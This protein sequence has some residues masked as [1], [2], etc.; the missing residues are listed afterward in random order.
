MKTNTW[1][2][3]A[4]DAL[5][6]I[7]RAAGATRM[8]GYNVAAEH[9]RLDIIGVYGPGW[10]ARIYRDRSSGTFFVGKTFKTNLLVGEQL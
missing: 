2:F 10:G 1:P 6:E 4:K 5:V 8:S 9:H 3:P 7:A